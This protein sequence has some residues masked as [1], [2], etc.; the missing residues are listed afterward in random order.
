MTDA[1]D[2]MAVVGRIA[3]AHGIRGE[4]IVN[5]DT[6][7]PERRFREGAAL[8]TRR[9]GAVET[10][11]VTTARIQRGRP[12]VGFEGFHTMNEAAALAGCELRVSPDELEPLPAG[13]YYH[14]DL[15]GCAVETASGTRIGIVGRVEGASGP[16]RLVVDAPD[17]E[18]L[19]PLAADICMSI[20]V[21]ARRIV[22][23]PP[24]G[25]LELNT[26]RGRRTRDAE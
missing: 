26:P 11:R 22:V 17:G 2:D 3:R 10:L 6:D 7:F 18:V 9:G 15:V 14:H 21:A 24:E 8:F 12:I 20:D 25:L 4:V 13:S 5:P 19:I 1:W 16:S 23:D